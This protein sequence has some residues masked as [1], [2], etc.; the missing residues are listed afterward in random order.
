MMTLEEAIQHAEEKGASML[1]NPRTTD[2]NCG[3]EHLQLADWLKQLKTYYEADNVENDGYL[4][5]E[6][7]FDGEEIETRL[8]PSNNVMRVHLKQNEP[9]SL[10]TF[11]TLIRSYNS[12]A[13]D[14]NGRMPRIIF[15][16]NEEDGAYTYDLYATA[17]DPFALN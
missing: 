16:C 12:A 3:L 14:S 17:I 6:T 9:P 1:M 13:I 5:E 15:D 4:V 8:S 7:G 11:R 10:N 2:C